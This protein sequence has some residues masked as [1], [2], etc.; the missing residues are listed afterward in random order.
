MGCGTSKG[1]RAKRALDVSVKPYKNPTDFSIHI[2][3]ISYFHGLVIKDYNRDISGNP[4][5]CEYIDCRSKSQ[6][7]SEHIKGSL[8]VDIK[9]FKSNSEDLGKSLKVLIDTK[10]V[11][12]IGEDLATYQD[13]ISDELIEVFNLFKEYRVH[14][15]NILILNASVGEFFSSFPYLK[16][17]NLE[18][19]HREK[20]LPI[21]LYDSADQ[22]KI[23]SD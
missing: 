13:Y 12:F 23:S 8:N 19:K 16:E 20:Y 2:I 17:G 21:L 7:Q 22:G 11:A 10:N 5:D 9:N 1:F 14:P 18:E 4:R 15:K 6:Y 3:N